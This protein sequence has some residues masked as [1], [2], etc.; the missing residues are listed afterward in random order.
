MVD[1][2]GSR[3]GIMARILVVDDSAVVR[4]VIRE[5][6]EF[7]GHDVLVAEDGGEALDLFRGDP[8][9]LVITD[10]VMPEKEGIETILELRELNSGVKILA[11][12]GGG[13]FSP[14]VHLTPAR[15]LGADE[16]LSKP[17]TARELIETVE[18]LLEGGSRHE[19][20]QNP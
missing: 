2:V 1:D 9:D 11:M 15:M 12:S 20:Q 8:T 6:L 3:R 14:E 4:R 7:E 5:A 13:L 10:I 17:F 19:E 16:T 18:R